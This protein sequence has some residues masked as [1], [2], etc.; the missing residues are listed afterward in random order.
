MMKN[1]LDTMQEIMQ[2]T[3]WSEGRVKEMHKER[4]FPL[5]KLGGRWASTTKEIDNWFNKQ[6]SLIPSSNKTISKPT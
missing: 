4:R 5:I 6:V 1:N 2:Y 3:G